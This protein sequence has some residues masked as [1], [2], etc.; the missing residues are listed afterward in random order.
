MYIACVFS[1]AVPGT[2]DEILRE[3]ILELKLYAGTKGDK[4]HAGFLAAVKQPKS[5]ASGQQ[6]SGG[7]GMSKTVPAGRSEVLTIDSRPNT[8]IGANNK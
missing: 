8:S 3:G 1:A 7:T 2:P 6:T 4:L 5:A